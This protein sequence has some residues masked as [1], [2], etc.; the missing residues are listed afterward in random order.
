MTRP[1][2][3]RGWGSSSEPIADVEL[4]RKKSGWRNA[5]RGYH[6]KAERGITGATKRN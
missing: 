5:Q 1:A 2:E 4:N 6:L 3:R